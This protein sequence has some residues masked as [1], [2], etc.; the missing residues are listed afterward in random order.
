MENKKSFVL[1]SDLMDIVNDLSDEQA[2]KL[3]KIIVDYV[4]DRNP[5]VEDQLLKIAFLPI[6]NQLKRDLKKWEDIKVK[7]S[8]SGKLGGRPKKQTKAKKA[9]G[10]SEKQTKA[11]KAVNVNVSVSDNVNVNDSVIN[12]E[13]VFNFKKEFLDMGV[14]KEILED[15]LK[16]RKNKKAT[17]SKTAFNGIVKKIE[18]S[19]LSANECIKISAENSWS[20]FNNKWIE[21]KEK[22]SA[23]KEKLNVTQRVMGADYEEI[24]ELIMNGSHN[25]QYK[26]ISG[27]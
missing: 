13:S 18:A 6:K 22:S 11:K 20:G 12:K 9:N 8:E 17:N 15:W 10:F 16:V 1:Y 2:G 14:E 4:N 25:P 19:G 5:E 23:K 26:K 3:I 21:E 24:K 27:E 7:R